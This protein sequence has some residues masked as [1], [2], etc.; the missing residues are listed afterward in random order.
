MALL[1]L[2][3]PVFIAHATESN[4]AAEC[5]VSLMS[6]EA[7][8]FKQALDAIQPEYKSRLEMVIRQLLAGGNARTIGSPPMY[9]VD[10]AAQVPSIALKM[11]FSA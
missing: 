9:P 11:D 2:V 6:K 1:K 5:C 3:L 10:G 8:S 7:G 4:V